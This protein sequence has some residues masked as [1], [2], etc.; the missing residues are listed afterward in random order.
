MRAKKQQSSNLLIYVK[1]H[2]EIK[3]QFQFLVTVF[4]S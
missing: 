4:E 3:D 1:Q 2:L